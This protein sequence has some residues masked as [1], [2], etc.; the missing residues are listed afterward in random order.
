MR[1]HRMLVAT[2]LTASSSLLAVV[3][4]GLPSAKVGAQ[5]GAATA[6]AYSGTLRATGVCPF[7]YVPR[8][9][10]PFRPVYLGTYSRVTTKGS[11]SGFAPGVTYYM[12]LQRY[13]GGWQR[14]PGHAAVTA[15]SAGRLVFRSRNL[16]LKAVYYYVGSGLQRADAMSIRFA[17]S[18][19]PGDQSWPPEHAVYRGAMPLFPSRNCSPWVAR[20]GTSLG[21]PGTAL[22]NG[23]YAFASAGFHVG[24]PPSASG[25]RFCVI[26]LSA[27]A[28]HN[29]WCT[30][31]NGKET[32]TIRFQRGGN[33]VVYS[34]GKAIWDSR[35]GGH[36]GAHLVLQR[37]RNLVIYTRAGT[38]LWQARSYVR[39]TGAW[40]IEPTPNRDT[41]G[42]GINELLGVSCTSGRACTAVGMHE[43][44][45]STPS[46]ALAERWNGA[47]WRIQPTVLPEG[48]ESTQLNG[49]SCTSATAC[50]AVGHAIEKSTHRAVNLA[51]AWNGSR[52]RLQSIPNPTGSTNATLLA[53]SCASPDACT[54]VGFSTTA[55]G[56]VAMAERWNG[57]TWRLQLLPEPASSELYG[58]SC[59]TAQICTAVGDY[60]GASGTRPFAERW[61]GGSWQI[62]TVPLPHGSS[63]GLLNAVSCTSPRACTATG[64]NFDT[65]PTLAERWNGSRWRVQSTPYPADSDLSRRLV[66]LN[67]V[68]CSSVTTCTATG[69]YA[70]GGHTRY[71]LET[72][73]DGSWRMVRAP[74]PAN[75]AAGALN[76][77]SCVPARC[78]AVGAWSGG[79]ISIATLALAD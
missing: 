40:S 29:Y 56:Q 6:G 70:P 19:D 69:V 12:Y 48:A 28:R 21:R 9:R 51:E 78:T 75:F 27:R 10:R 77:M 52:W 67:S 37:D 13:D 2:L 59:P 36:P 30:G 25:G 49:V 57:R 16:G 24:A 4:T 3:A 62:Q 65:P 22:V 11:L 32:N 45:M 1:S 17:V 50:I 43:A 15:S 42:T 60:R 55:S 61:D 39:S 73:G 64:A 33:L 7:A 63:G 23:H 58:V 47:S 79:S 34:R 74:R 66:T 5:S 38:V 44:S 14:V 18:T 41:T 72:W 26:D 31:S 71:F 20:T 68:S 53:M 35:T 46:F 54:A 76:A 8:I